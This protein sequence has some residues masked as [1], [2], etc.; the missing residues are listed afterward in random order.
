MDKFTKVRHIGKGN[1]GAC[2]LVRNNE[3]GKC[4]VIKQVDLGRL[5]RKE[6][7]QSLNEAHLLSSLQHPNIINYVDSFLSKKSDHLCIVMEFADC[8]DLSA[9]IKKSYGVNFRESQVLDWIIQLVLSLSYVHQRRI[10]HRDIK[11][12]N[13]F[14]TSQNI[15]KLGDFGI[16]CTLSGTYDQA[17]TFVG[18]PYYLSPE[19]ILERPYDHRSD[20]WALGVV[21]YELMALRHPFNA[22]NMKGLMQRILRVQYEPVPKLYSTELRDIV[23]R[24]LVREPSQRIKLEELLELPVVQRRMQE[25]MSFDVM[26][27]SYIETLVQHKL[28]PPAIAALRRSSIPSAVVTATDSSASPSLGDASHGAHRAQPESTVEAPLPPLRSDRNLMPV[29]RCRLLPLEQQQQRQ[30]E[31]EQQEHERRKSMLPHQR[32]LLPYQS[33]VPKPSIDVNRLDAP[34]MPRR[35]K[36][37]YLMYKN[38]N[39]G[40]NS[41]AV[42]GDGQKGSRVSVPVPLQT[43]SN[44][45]VHRVDISHLQP[46]GVGGAQR[47]PHPRDV[48]HGHADVG[49]AAFVYASSPFSNRPDPNAHAVGGLPCQIKAE[50]DKEGV[51]PFFVDHR[52]GKRGQQG[53]SSVVSCLN[54]FFQQPSVGVSPLPCA[55]QLPNMDIKAMLQRAALERAQRHP[56]S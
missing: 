10:L 45:V 6:R 25:W 49:S 13:V 52:V 7:Q 40:Y 43:P 30:Q 53:S 9:R 34:Q 50:P 11:S 44:N 46:L 54:P 8:G 56:F 35:A 48:S 2:A 24:L 27:K 28:L 21:I 3:D 36:S 37:R 51:N 17:R 39:G 20:M 41:H 1:M 31:Q 38:I 23:P 33:P 29:Q 26:P 55:P 18:T 32:H 19:L 14:L 42:S 15:L 16:A 5:S 47:P 4:Y 12:Q 22:S